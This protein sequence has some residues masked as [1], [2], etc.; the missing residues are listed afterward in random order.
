MEYL[1][2]RGI[3]QRTSHE[4]IGRL[5][6]LCERRGLRRLADLSDAEFA[7]A[8]PRLG[9]EVRGVLGVENAVKAFRSYGSTAPAE[10]D[11]QL[12]RWKTRLDG[13]SPEAR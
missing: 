5:V 12:Q 4:I 10:V 2:G 13:A 9:P 7:E 6:G 3:P 1:I 8:D 11:R